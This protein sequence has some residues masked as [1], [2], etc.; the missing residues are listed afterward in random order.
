MLIKKNIMTKTFKYIPRAV[1][2]QYSGPGY[3]FLCDIIFFVSNKTD[4]RVL[5]AFR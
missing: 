5:N 2:G 4:A 1:I 3:L